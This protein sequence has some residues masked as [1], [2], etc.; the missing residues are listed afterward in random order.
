MTRKWRIVSRVFVCPAALLA[1]LLL[2]LP[3]G[4]VADEARNSALGAPRNNEPRVPDSISTLLA[5][6]E[7][8]IAADD[9]AGQ[10][11]GDPAET[12]ADLLL[13]L[14]G[15]LPSEVALLAATPER[16]A[17]RAGEA[18]A[19]G[20]LDEAGRFAAMSDILGD[21]LGRKVPNDES[22]LPASPVTE[23]AGVPTASVKSPHV[24]VAASAPSPASVTAQ[25][26]NGPVERA[27]RAEAIPSL[28]EKLEHQVTEA[29]E[30][31]LDESDVMADILL[32]LPDATPSEAKMAW[33]TPAHFKR[34]A[35]E[36]QAAGRGDEAS[37]FTALA[38]VFAE[39]L[40]GW[41]SNS[42]VRSL[43]PSAAAA[44]DV[45]V[46]PAA[47]PVE[48]AD[49]PAAASADQDR[50]GLPPKPTPGEPRPPMAVSALLAELEQQLAE[51]HGTTIDQSD[52]VADILL[53]LPTATRSEAE[54]VSATPS[55]FADRAREAKAAGRDDEAS[56]F[57]MLADVLQGLIHGDSQNDAGEQQ[58]PRPATAEQPVVAAKQNPADAGPRE[59]GRDLASINSVSHGYT[60]VEADRMTPP[61]SAAVAGRS[62]TA[63]S[64]R[65]D[66]SDITSLDAA[67]AGLHTTQP[68]VPIDAATAADERQ[69]SNLVAPAGERLKPAESITSLLTKLEQ[70]VA[71]TDQA[72]LDEFDTIAD[73]LLS[74]PNAPPSDA[75]LILATPSRFV[76]RARM[77]KAAGRDGE[78]S[79]FGTMADVLA[80][81]MEKSSGDAVGPSR[82]ARSDPGV[83][84]ATA[85]YDTTTAPATIPGDQDRIR[86]G[87]ALTRMPVG[88]NPTAANPPPVAS[89][90][91]PVKLA[92]SISTPN[93]TAK[94]SPS[95]DGL[96]IARLT[97]DA[98]R[99]VADTP[100]QPG[101]GPHSR[102]LPGMAPAPSVVATR[103][104]APNAIGLETTTNSMDPQC[105]AIQLKFGLGEEPSDAE[106]SYL[107]HG[108]RPHG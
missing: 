15:A 19:V 32:S 83:L 67:G 24:A 41:A 7:L 81:L 8:Q 74:M 17:K 44:P 76:E 107:R 59:A 99:S 23:S 53:R 22:M 26:Q 43:E 86:N 65:D 5:K 106:R 34:R 20:H 79:R 18:A 11:S 3:E 57:S 29:R 9:R 56:R 6:L 4:A 97:G 50:I 94:A 93:T 89:K 25:S 101:P 33:A 104:A 91:P 60:K 51:A 30:A 27:S 90:S 64:A 77:A 54:L 71:E 21:L 66:H 63:V 42:P 38:G 14:P 48:P 10:R 45:A 55:H 68:K 47:Q 87:D 100:I 37:R 108:C 96:K 78:A 58:T 70:K 85:S 88:P 40:D 31:T 2:I 28:L 73:I 13:L 46:E 49:V 35:L 80:G 75:K 98:E 12:I 16:F 36:A 82:P 1:C 62:P 103:L 105:R 39:L 95:R 61:A 92:A 69:W 102:A 84:S 72:T 52:L